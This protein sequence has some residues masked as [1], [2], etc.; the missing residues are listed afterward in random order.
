MMI[1]G[2]TLESEIARTH[3]DLWMELEFS[4]EASFH[5]VLAYSAAHL[6]YLRSEPTPALAIIHNQEAIRIIN[7]WLQD[8]V[9]M[10]SDAAIAAVLR[11]TSLE[12]SISNLTRWS[13]ADEVLFCHLEL[14][15][16]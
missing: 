12:V 1:Y 13:N 9:M 5:G 10:I 16:K 3:I 4:N 8:P 11:Q 15:G 14:V 2:D 6:A 7:H